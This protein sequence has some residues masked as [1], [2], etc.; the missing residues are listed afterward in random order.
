MIYTTGSIAA[1]GNTLTGTGTNFT[2][3]GSLIRTG[4]TLVSLANPVQVFQITAINSA[5]QLTVTPAATPAIAAGTAYAILLS[6][7]LSVD[8]LASNVAETYKMFQQ[9]MTGFV[10]VMLGVS[11]VTMIINGTA[12]T[13]PSQRSL[14]KKGANSDITSLSGLTTALSIKQGGTGS[15]TPFGTLAGSFCQGNDGRLNTVDQKTGGSLIGGV[16]ATTASPASAPAN[17]TITN[18]EAVTSRFRNGVYSAVGFSLYSQVA[19]GTGSYGYLQLAT[20]GPLAYWAFSQTGVATGVA[21]TPTC[22]E[23]LKNIEGPIAAPLDKMRLMRGQSWRW[24]SNG[25]YGIGL[26]AQDVQRAFPDAVTETQDVELPDGTLVKNVLSP[27]SYGVAAALHHE[28]ILAL[29]DKIESLEAK[30]LAITS[31]QENQPDTQS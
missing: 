27:D 25:N 19:Q 28:A 22:D 20:G 13:V 21:W 11:D 31:S 17:G 30:I 2:A 29:M 24:K 3:A 18:S 12:V 23:R 16:A 1:N 9:N 6:D 14:A 10:D 8:G 5:T 26:T 4:C 15:D 7:S